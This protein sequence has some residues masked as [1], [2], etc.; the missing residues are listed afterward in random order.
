MPIEVN[1][2][3]Y[4]EEVLNS[5]IPVLVDFWGPKCA[6]CLALMPSVKEIEEKHK[7]RL[8]VTKFD[9]SQNRR[10]C[11]NLK[12]MRLPT[13]LLYRDGQEIE[14]VIG[15]MTPTELKEKIDAFVGQGN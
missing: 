8:K 10:M 1:K 2:E 13:F 14:R 9:A 6:N 11:M 15:E 3:N 12:V 5:S 4:E 7:D